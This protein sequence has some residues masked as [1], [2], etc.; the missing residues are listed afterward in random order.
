MGN[1]PHNFKVH[2]ALNNVKNGVCSRIN[3]HVLFDTTRIIDFAFASISS[4]LK[5]FKEAFAHG[6]MPG[7]FYI[8]LFTAFIA[9][10]IATDL[11]NEVNKNI[12]SV[13]CANAGRYIHELHETTY[14]NSDPSKTWQH[15]IYE[16]GGN[17][18]YED[19]LCFT[20]FL[21]QFLT[22]FS[23]CV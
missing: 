7:M 5:V 1:K 17:T 10:S 12:L 19:L 13:N 11:C 21:T 2:R 6:G 18:Q 3:V 16:E 20:T 22:L 23:C 4:D 8:L 15:R 9:L 14:R